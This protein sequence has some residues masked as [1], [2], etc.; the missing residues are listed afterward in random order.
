MRHD[1]SGGGRSRRENAGYAYVR[2]W[3]PL[4]TPVINA[5]SFIQF[6]PDLAYRL[7]LLW[8]KTD[9]VR[10]NRKSLLGM[11]AITKFPAST[12][13]YMR[14]IIRR[15]HK[16]MLVLNLNHAHEVQDTNNVHDDEV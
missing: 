16:E 3:D 1:C 8:P 2:P 10:R 11:R 12:F 15:L 9:T 5:F 14:D 6:V 13:Q 7:A 4:A